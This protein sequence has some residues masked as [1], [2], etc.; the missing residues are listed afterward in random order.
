MNSKLEKVL[1]VLV[2]YVLLITFRFVLPISEPLS[3]I[4]K[5]V[6]IFLSVLVTIIIYRVYIYYRY[7]LLLKNINLLL[8]TN[9]LD[10][11]V[12]Y[13]N[14]FLSGRKKSRLA[15]AYKLY[16][17]AMCGQ[18][19]EFEKMLCE[20]KLSN[21]YKKIFKL[22]FVQGSISIINYFKTSTTTV[23]F[24]NKQGWAEMINILLE[25]D[26]EKN[27]PI[28]LSMYSNTKFAMIKS[29]CALKL[30]LTYF[31]IENFE[32]AEHFYNKALEYAPS[33]EVAYYIEKKT[34]QKTG[35]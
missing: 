17:L 33:L 27:I 9:Q 2:W 11:A 29:V 23:M 34:G 24:I 20:C 4:D 26:H 14:R 13:I 35:D 12:K 5:Y 7:R 25:K 22:D 30:Y 15:Y 21:K 18:I 6:V 28:L 31:E 32:K 10:E 8:E 19:T 3:A 16:V 1:L